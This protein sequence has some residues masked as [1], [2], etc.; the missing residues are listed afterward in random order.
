VSGASNRRTLAR[1]DGFAEWYDEQLAVPFG[2]IGGEAA[3]Q[4]LG[5]GSGR[6][7]DVC[8][9]TG[10]HLDAFARLGWQMTGLD[11]S[12]D[13]LRIARERV[14]NRAIDL[15]QGDAESLPFEAES[16]DAVVSLFSHTD[17]D[18]FPAVVCEVARVL[19]PG[20]RFVYVGVHPCFV[21]PHSQERDRAVPVLHA[22]YR[23]SGRYTDGPGISPDG[24]WAKVSGMH[25]TLGSL[26]QSVLDAALILERFDEH[27]D[28]DYPRS[29]ALRARRPA[30]RE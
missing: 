13:Q 29:I 19:R 15:I 27:G 14:A 9:G 1:Y 12:D 16:F 18:D 23:A 4:L 21:G 5:A 25:V 11:I 3:M 26:I 10:V 22:G 24:L 8:C 30:R 17:V 7:L 6:C 2:A 28:H 20:G